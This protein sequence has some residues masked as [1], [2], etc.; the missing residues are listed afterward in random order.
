M[1]N[2]RQDVQHETAVTII[3]ARRPPEKI[4]VLTV[5]G[6]VVKLDASVARTNCLQPVSIHPE[7]SFICELMDEPLTNCVR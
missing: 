6:P 2:N 4:E 5:R 3:N 7:G 1:V